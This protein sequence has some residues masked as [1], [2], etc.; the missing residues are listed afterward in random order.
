MRLAPT[1]KPFVITNNPLEKIFSS[2]KWESLFLSYVAYLS[3]T[4]LFC[5]GASP[6]TLYFA[7]VF[8]VI[9]SIWLIASSRLHALYI[10]ILV[11]HIGPVLRISLPRIGMF[12][13]GDV[14]LLLLGLS[15]AFR[16]GRGFLTG[17]HTSLGSK[18]VMPRNFGLAVLLTGLTVALSANYRNVASGTLAMIQIALVYLITIN[19]VKTRKD[20]NGIFYA[21]AFAVLISALMHLY[22]YSTGRTMMVNA[23]N[24]EKYADNILGYV[25]SPFIKTSFFYGS[26]IISCTAIVILGFCYIFL[27]EGLS[28]TRYLFWTVVIIFITISSALSSRSPLIA[29]FLV[30]IVIGVMALRKSILRKSPRRRMLAASLVIIVLIVFGTF[31]T[32]QRLVSEEQRDSY[33]E[34]FAD[35]GGSL[36]ERFIIWREA[37]E[38]VFEFPKEFLVGVGPNVPLKDGNPEAVEQLTYSK[39]FACNIQSFHNFY[40]DIIFQNGIL[41]FA[42][43]MTAIVRI[44]KNLFYIIKRSNCTDIIACGCFFPVLGC[45]LIFN[46]QGTTW[47]KPLLVLAQLFGIAYLLASG[48]LGSKG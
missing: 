20:A 24:L 28:L 17:R 7:G 23:E 8:A 39:T 30:G 41:F 26:F 42:V 19:E 40:I 10:V 12:N 29:V 15:F 36:S 37:F 27:S 4:V 45:L 11:V 33:Y 9:T 13:I 48:R 21:L 32:F 25:P 14:F 34:M 44:L 18:F 3:V 43:M 1:A 35:G 46:T 6:T 47:S 38:K 31:A 22:F 2:R 16:W 5:V